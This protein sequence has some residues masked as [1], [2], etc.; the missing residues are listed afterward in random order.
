MIIN[1]DQYI[2]QNNR[3]YH[4]GHNC[5]ALLESLKIW[6]KSFKLTFVDLKWRQIQQ[7]HVLQHFSLKNVF[8]N[9]F[10]W[11][12]LVQFE[13][14]FWTSRHDSLALNFRRNQTHVTRSSNQL[15]VFIFGRQYRLAPPAVMEMY[16]VSSLWC[17]PRHFFDQLG[18][19]D[20]SNCLF[21]QG[22]AVWLV[23]NCL[24]REEWRRDSAII[25]FSR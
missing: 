4:F 12:I 15:P 3:D 13:I 19:T 25:F 23:C 20:Q 14:V 7:L 17:V 1:H 2:D 9:T 10:Q 8:R 5:A 6:W 16:Y 18:E 24:Y 11:T 21:C 22:S